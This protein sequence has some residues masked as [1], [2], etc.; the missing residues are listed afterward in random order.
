MYLINLLKTQINIYPY[1]WPHIDAITKNVRKLKIN[2]DNIKISNT[3][4]IEELIMKC[5]VID[6]ISDKFPNLKKLE[7]ICDR[8]TQPLNFKNLNFLKIK[9]VSIDK[10]FRNSN[11]EN[12]I[13]LEMPNE[14]IEIINKKNDNLK[15]LK[16]TN[17]N[18]ANYIDIEK[19]IGNF[20]K[21]ICLNLR[22]RCNSSEND[23]EIYINNIYNLSTL[24]LTLFGV[25]L[26]NCNNLN[27]LKNLKIKVS[28]LKINYKV[29]EKFNQLKKLNLKRIEK[30]QIID[31]N[32]KI[33][34]DNLS[35]KKL[36]DNLI[37]LTYLKID[38]RELKIDNLDSLKHLKYLKHLTIGLGD[39]FVNY[40]G[41]LDNLIYLNISIAHNITIQ[42]LSNLETL[43]I[44][45]SGNIVISSIS[46]E[47]IKKIKICHCNGV[48]FKNNTFLKLLKLKIINSNLYINNEVNNNSKHTFD[49]NII[50][51]L[52]SLKIW[53][54]RDNLDINYEFIKNLKNLKK[55]CISNDSITDDVFI[56]LK[57]LI[58][59]RTTSK[60]ITDK[61]FENFSLSK[62][63]EIINNDNIT[64]KIFNN[65]SNIKKISIHNCSNI[66]I[67][68]LTHFNKIKS[69][70]FTN[71]ND[72]NYVCGLFDEDF[73]LLIS[74]FIN[75]YNT[76]NFSDK[77]VN[78][79]NY[80]GDC[81]RDVIKKCDSFMSKIKYI[82]DEY[83][84]NY[85]I[86]IYPNCDIVINY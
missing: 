42:K 75:K 11:L 12:L 24:K 38:C 30:I 45:N 69:I 37:N 51:N 54:D 28:Y 82:M 3:N 71:H 79:K 67:K 63:L 47:Q 77:Y 72:C 84:I 26:L 14:D 81:Y 56:N 83:I 10:S 9:Y 19:K 43:I 52:V 57:K 44:R 25:I 2:D 58:K 5:S 40:N 15:Y 21:L 18:K 16:F 66:N 22:F 48:I 33:I 55:L 70:E 20:K 4:L 32:F 8:I 39:N 60:K 35:I 31:S 29:L 59:F 62:Y 7:I 80:K 49:N 73:M 6:K 1:K 23:E 34:N 46:S 65:M 50:D 86:N 41:C 78:V 74:K 64:D 76:Y 13:Y 85:L 36:M 53:S 68:A 61:I 17:I 27:I